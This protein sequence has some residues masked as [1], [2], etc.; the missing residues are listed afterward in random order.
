MGGSWLA[1]VKEGKRAETRKTV[2]TG[3]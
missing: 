3:W 2:D 1:G